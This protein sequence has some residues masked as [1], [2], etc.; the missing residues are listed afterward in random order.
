MHDLRTFLDTV[1]RER[2]RDIINISRPVSPK[3]E[4]AAILTKLEQSYRFPI[5]FFHNVAGSPFPVVTNVCGSIARLALALGCSVGELSRVYAARCAQP[6]K[7]VITNTAPVQGQVLTGQEVNLESFPRFVYHE[8]DASQPYI[9]AAIV[10]ARDPETG[11]SNLSFH[12]L[13]IIDR[14]TTAMFMARGK[15]LE[16][17]Y[18]K[19]EDSGEAMPIAAF[20]GVHPTCSLGA[21]YTGSTDTEEYDIIGGLQQS[22]LQLVNCLTNPLQVPA[23]AEFALEGLV[24]PRTRVDE[25]PFGEFTGYSTGSMACPVFKVQAVTSRQNPIFQDIVSGHSEHLSLPVLGME[26]HLLE[27]SRGVAPTTL[28]VRLLVPLTAFVAVQKKDDAQP[29]RIIE[30]LLASD[31]YVKQVIVVDADVD[32]SDLRQVATAIALHVRPDRDVYIHRPTL[33]TELD[34]SCESGDGMT[35]KLGIDATIPLQSRQR[36]VRNRVPQQVLDSINLSEFLHTV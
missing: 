18:R 6:I 24:P 11:K 21:L 35:A 29:Q 9:T 17:I 27:A 30:T 1:R 36:V 22:P 7:P 13:M 4:T 19:Y 12:R 14:D 16:K 33:G 10:V 26:H 31:I 3:H 15:H 20:L 25:G 34:P 2:P 32:I 28:S 8:D 5:L 23:E